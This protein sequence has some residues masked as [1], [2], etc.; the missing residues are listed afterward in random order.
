MCSSDLRD[1]DDKKKNFRMECFVC[2]ANGPIAETKFDAEEFWEMRF[3][4]KHIGDTTKMNKDTTQQTDP[5]QELARIAMHLDGF[6]SSNNDSTY[7][8]FLRLLADYRHLQA[9]AAEAAI[10]REEEKCG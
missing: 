9:M 1:E 6:A 8:C 7:L 2:F 3:P 4:V 10:E 5:A